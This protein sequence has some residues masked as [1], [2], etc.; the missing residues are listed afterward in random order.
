MMLYQNILDTQTWN[1]KPKCDQ[2]V[3]ISKLSK[4]FYQ[5]LFIFEWHLFILLYNNCNI[6]FNFR[7]EVLISCFCDEKSLVYCS[8]IYQIK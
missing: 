8:G 7:Y 6:T 2:V 3:T 5:P 1:P 4:T